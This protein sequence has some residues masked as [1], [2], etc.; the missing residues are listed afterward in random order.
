MH[1][2]L[3]KDPIIRE[4][5][6][7]LNIVLPLVGIVIFAVIGALYFWRLYSFDKTIATIEVVWDE[8]QY[9][10]SEKYTFTF[11]QLSFTRI[12]SDGQSHSCR[13][14]FRIGKPHDLFQ[15]GD[16]LEI[17]PASGTCQRAD[18]IGRAD[19]SE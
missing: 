12:A 18:I 15:V 11:A 13:H 9:G 5:L 14:A 19:R 4:Q 16:K 7:R 1:S 2:Y 10:K 3:P 8:E 6:R 17:I